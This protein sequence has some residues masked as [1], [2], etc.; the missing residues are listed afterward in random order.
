VINLSINSGV[1]A[2]YHT[3]PLNAAAEILWFSGVVV[4]V[5]AGNSGGQDGY[6]TVNAPPANDPFLITVGASDE[7]GTSAIH[8]DGVAPYSA[9]GK[10]QDGFIKPDIV[11]PGTGIYS[12]RARLSPWGLLYPDRLAGNG[13]Y[14]RLSG[15][16]MAAPMVVGV[17][18]LMLQNEP[19]LTPDQVKY[20][21]LHS[22]GRTLSVPLDGATLSLPYLD[23]NG[24][25]NTTTSESANTGL[26]AS[27]LLWSGSAPVQWSSVN[28]NSVNW[29]S[30]NWNS[31]NWNS[32]NWNSVNWNSAVLEPPSI[33]GILPLAEGETWEIPAWPTEAPDLEESLQLDNRL[34]LPALAQ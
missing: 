31:V 9:Y 22:T 24:A 29:N 12:V 8:D 21:L 18:A 30:V 15:T 10:T 3:S 1:E 27:Q 26:Q 23:G 13:Q 16:S 5:S 32:V 2:S 28:W 34:F 20:R 33:G 7:K 17:V 6:N 14:F 19:N 11:A 4:V 25:V